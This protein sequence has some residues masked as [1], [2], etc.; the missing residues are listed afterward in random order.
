MLLEEIRKFTQL[1]LEETKHKKIYLVSHF[2]TDGITSA[3]II[4]KTLEKL[5]KQFSLKILKQLN[6]EE[7]N[8]FP[9]DKVILILDLGSGNIEELSKLKD[10]VFILDHHEIIEKPLSKNIILLNP[11]LLNKYEELCSAELCYLFSKQI[12]QENKELAHL[13]ILGAVGDTLEKDINKI[14]NMIIQDA[15]VKVKKG[16]LIYPSTRPLDKALEFSSRPFIPGV[17]GDCLGTYELLQEAGIEK[18]G[19]TYKSLIDLND[20]EM[21]KL[22][23]A[24]LL[25]INSKEK[26]NEY[27]GNLY[28]I[29]FF[30]K[31]EDAREL[32]A[33][34]NACSKME[35]THISL[36]LC[37][38][39]SNARKQAERIYVKY[40]QHIISGLK[41]ID[42]N[43]KIQ[44]KQYVIINAQ[45]NIKDTIIGTLASIISFSSVYKEG[46]III[47]MAY[48][49]D[50]IKVSTRISG[51]N[52]RDSRNL[53]EL[54]TS[55]TQIIGGYS[56][57]H[58]R[59]A[60]C[61]IDKENEEKFI[62]L[63][64]R[65]LDVELVKI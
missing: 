33:I 64:K 32:S 62:E 12:S 37:M 27:V 15:K 40:R 43:E 29:K 13:A 54:M 48:N 57:G 44:G 47:A 59:A 28:L 41:Y 49:E 1:F 14:R 21:K 22:V 18:L 30:N 42:K 45:N 65:K 8:S 51:R 17:T 63:L 38:G 35:K 46:T 24:V 9:E 7:I 60:G 26:T 55:I 56:G 31:I 25:R 4:S 34:I 50:K 52:P 53:K 2:D 39:N 19:K 58:K 5:D 61:T 10:K 36:M 20:Y 6:Q 16:L 11:H 23:T 3:A